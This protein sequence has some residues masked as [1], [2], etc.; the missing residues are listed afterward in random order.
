MQYIASTTRS[1]PV[2]AKWEQKYTQFK[3]FMLFYSL[4]SE[5]ILIYLH[6]SALTPHILRST[7]A[8]ESDGV[9]VWA[10]TRDQQTPGSPPHLTAESLVDCKQTSAEFH[11]RLGLI[12][13]LKAP[14]GQKHHPSH[15][16]PHFWSDL[17]LLERREKRMFVE[18]FQ[19]GVKVSRKPPFWQHL[20]MWL[21]TATWWNKCKHNCTLTIR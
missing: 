18:K 17:A 11:V 19:V 7:E 13:P 20:I 14:V 15:Y 10:A 8:S 3:H 12:S 21:K 5:V 2:G 9:P 6:A 16:W 1:T 4:R